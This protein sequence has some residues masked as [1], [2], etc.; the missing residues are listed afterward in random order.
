MLVS[1]TTTATSANTNVSSNDSTGD[2][3]VQL[4][5]SKTELKP[6]DLELIPVDEKFLQERYGSFKLLHNNCDM[7][8]VYE[9]KLISDTI[10]PGGPRLKQSDSVLNSLLKAAETLNT[11]VVASILVSKLRSNI[12]FVSKA[13]YFTII[14]SV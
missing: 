5:K 3:S 9:D 8:R 6:S 13:V 11:P 2:T 4:S 10:Q 14:T 12:N 1:T 7:I